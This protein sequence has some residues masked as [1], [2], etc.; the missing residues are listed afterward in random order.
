MLSPPCY[1]CGDAYD[2]ALRELARHC[3]TR[4]GADAATAMLCRFA[5]AD[6]VRRRRAVL[7]ALHGLLR[8]DCIAETWSALATLE[9]PAAGPPRPAP[10]RHAYHAYIAPAASF[11]AVPVA[12]VA[13]PCFALRE[14]GLSAHLMLRCVCGALASYRALMCVVLCLYARDAFCAVKNA[15]RASDAMCAYV[16][17]ESRRHSFEV[18]VRRLWRCAFAED[19]RVLRV[20]GCPAATESDTPQLAHAMDALL[21]LA[22]HDFGEPVCSDS[23]ACLCIHI[24]EA[25]ALTR[26]VARVQ[27]YLTIGLRS[28]DVPAQVF[29]EVRF[30]H[31]DDL[32]T[33]VAS[34]LGSSHV[35]HIVWS[36]VLLGFDDAECAAIIAEIDIALRSHDSRCIFVTARGLM[37]GCFAGAEPL[38]HFEGG[39]LMHGPLGRRLARGAQ[40]D[41]R[42]V[43]GLLARARARLKRCAKSAS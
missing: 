32:T 26:Y 20:F 10:L 22:S 33:C 25:G 28:A 4:G 24:D 37:R 40:S 1:F 27:A 6:T 15:L 42:V 17:H 36:D 38:R 29:R 11:L 5:D 41:T 9:A 3:K 13:L 14:Y 43:R 23:V 16:A 18:H 19:K 2:G 35:C 30:H 21:A 7:V 12:F 39:R 31:H 8:L 34:M